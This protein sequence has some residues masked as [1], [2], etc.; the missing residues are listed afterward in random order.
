MKMKIQKTTLQAVFSEISRF[1]GKGIMQHIHLSV[2]EKDGLTFRATDGEVT[3]VKKVA[4]SN[5][6]DVIVEI[7]TPG[8]L[9]L[10]PKLEEV[11]RKLSSGMMSVTLLDTNQIEVKQGKT[12]AKINGV[13][14]ELPGIPE[15]VKGDGITLTTEVLTMLVTQTAFSASDKD[16]RP[17]LKAVNMQ[18]DETSFRVTSTDSHRLS[19]KTIPKPLKLPTLNIP[20]KRLAEVVNTLEEKQQLS[21]IPAGNHILIQTS[22]REVYIRQL[23]GEYPN[24]SR[25][26]Q[27]NASLKVKVNRQELLA[28]INRSLTFAKDEQYRSITLEPQESALRIYSASDES[29]SIE[30]TLEAAIDG[31]P[32]KFTIN[33][34][35]VSD[36]LKAF[37]TE[38]VTLHIQ[39]NE[40][41][42]FIFSEK[43]PTLT[44]LV[45]PIRTA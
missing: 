11:T 32:V 31:E 1:R 14:G 13:D 30:E 5:G 7:I 29:G 12:S 6:E 43:D 24:T 25:L 10:P 28:S 17:I 9:L 36:A 19:Q 15:H 40:K 3:Y 8:E 37:T 41:P 27:C 22:D 23:E 4:L 42:I 44:Q 26:I 33:A 45:L 16:G 20:A 39:S 18:S 34:L 35:F 38:E 2:S 21:L